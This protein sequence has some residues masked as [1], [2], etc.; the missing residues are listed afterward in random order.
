MGRSSVI[1]LLPVFFNGQ[2]TMPDWI[3][4]FIICIDFVLV[5]LSLL[6]LLLLRLTR[7]LA[8]LV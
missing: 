6:S 5:C 1:F 7:D 3:P 2:T 4:I 8:R